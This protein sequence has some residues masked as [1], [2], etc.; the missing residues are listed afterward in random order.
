MIFKLKAFILFLYGI[1]FA[2]AFYG[3]KDIY[4]FILAVVLGYYGF[5]GLIERANK[6]ND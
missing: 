4:A 1:Y 6:G 5:L 3:N 2:I